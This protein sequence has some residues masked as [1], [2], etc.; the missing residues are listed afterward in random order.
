VGGGRRDL[1]KG[2]AGRGTPYLFLSSREDKSSGCNM[3]RYSV[4][5]GSVSP[6]IS[7]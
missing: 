6:I 2:R 1:T 3:P 5:I 7:A 4:V